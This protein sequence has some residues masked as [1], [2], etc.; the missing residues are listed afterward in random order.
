[1]EGWVA[2]YCC[3]QIFKAELA[4]QHLANN[5]LMA[6]VVN[7]KDSFYVTIGDVE[8]YVAQEDVEMATNLLKDF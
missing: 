5:D 1:M 2:V 3:D 4:R 6:M 8:V 7:K